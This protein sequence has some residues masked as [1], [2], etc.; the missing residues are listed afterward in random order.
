MQLIAPLSLLRD[1]ELSVVFEYI[2]DK[3]TISSLFKS[4]VRLQDQ[5]MRIQKNRIRCFYLLS[6]IYH[7]DRSVQEF[8][9]KSRTRVKLV[10]WV[11]TIAPL[12]YQLDR[13]ELEV[14]APPLLSIIKAQPSDSE[15]DIIDRRIHRLFLKKCLRQ[16]EVISYDCLGHIFSLIKEEFIDALSEHPDEV[17]SLMDG[18]ALPQELQI[19]SHEGEESRLLFELES[20]SLQARQREAGELYLLPLPARIVQEESQSLYDDIT[21]MNPIVSKEF[22]GILVEIEISSARKKSWY[23]DGVPLRAQNDIF[24]IGKYLP[25]S[26][27]L[28]KKEGDAI[29]HGTTRFTICQSRHA[30]GSSDIFESLLKKILEDEVN[31]P[32]SPIG[33]EPQLLHQ[34]TQKIKQKA[35]GALCAELN[36]AKSLQEKSKERS[37]IENTELISDEE[38]IPQEEAD[39]LNCFKNGCAII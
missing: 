21:L 22:D 11:N 26:F 32:P 1:D 37:F 9:A 12:Y 34:N 27:L 13:S 19:E 24:R 39:L 33:Y 2:G 38:T 28:G 3:R 23:D 16:S 31:T 10:S 4:S 5:I 17:I 18:L 15:G 14:I 6:Q 20:I 25:V 30:F 36:R 8:Y 29:H 35:L 7:A